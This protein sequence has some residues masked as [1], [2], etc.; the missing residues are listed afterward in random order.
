MI[1]NLLADCDGGDFYIEVEHN[2]EVR[3]Y[4]QSAAEAFNILGQRI[5]NAEEYDATADVRDCE[6]GRSVYFLAE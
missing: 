2:H 6:E 1:L 3:G 4:G 5:I